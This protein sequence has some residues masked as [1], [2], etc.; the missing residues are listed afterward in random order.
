MFAKVIRTARLCD[1]AVEEAFGK[2]STSIVNGDVSFKA[3][4]RA[5]LVGRLN[6]SG[7][8]ATAIVSNIDLRR[9]SADAMSMDDILDKVLVGF[10]PRVNMISVVSIVADDGEGDKFVEKVAGSDGFVHR[11]PEYSEMTDLRDFVSKRMN[12][13]FFIDKESRSTFIVVSAMN[14]RRF[15]YLQSFIPRYLPWLFK[16]KPLAEDEIALLTSLTSKLSSDYERIIDEFAEKFDVRGIMIK[17]MVG[18]YQRRT[19]ERQIDSAR[20]E[21]RSV[22]SDMN[23]LLERY[24]DRVRSRDTLNIRIM[25]LTSAMDQDNDDDELV[26][27]FKCNKGVTPIGIR[28]SRLTVIVKT[29][30]D[31]FDPDAFDTLSRRS[32]S[33]MYVGYDIGNYAFQEFDDRKLFLKAIFG[34]DPKLKVKTCAVYYLDVMGSVNTS[35]HYDYPADCIDYMPNPHINHH[36]CLGNHARYI[37]ERLNSGDMVGAIE[38]CVSSAKSINLLEGAS[39]RPFLEDLFSSRCSKCIEL[40]DGSSVTPEDAL[41]WLK[42]QSE[43]ESEEG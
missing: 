12:A 41:A 3:T 31:S 28:D 38:Q 19:R 11:N 30:I 43:G 39:V 13:R 15:H 34:E 21:L 4:M 26:E 29:Y 1:E 33:H 8:N 16:D 5:L 32:G 9:R 36:A 22:M 24:A 40:P 6:G 37:C 25:G 10:V 23:N 2:V 18:N 27:Y 35:S 42:F 7:E 17:N 20:S 14:S